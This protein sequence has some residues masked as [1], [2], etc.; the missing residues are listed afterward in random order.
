MN[1]RFKGI[2][3]IIF[4]AIAIFFLAFLYIFN[5]THPVKFSYENG[6]SNVKYE[7]ARV[8]EVTNNNLRKSINLTNIYFGSQKVKVK[9]LTGEH[10]GDIKVVQNY[11]TDIHN[12]F[13]RKGMVIVIE[14]DTVNQ[15]KYTAIVYNY[16]RA[17]VEYAFIFIFFAAL[18][19]IGGKNGFKSIIGIVF[20]LIC[21]IFLFVPM[22]YNGY[23]PI[24]ACLLIVV[25]TTFTTLFLLDGISAKTISAA[26]GTILGVVISIIVGIIFGGL[27]HLSGLNMENAETL[28]LISTKTDMRVQGL[29]LTCVIIASLGALLD[30]SVSMASS[31]QEV[32]QSN[33]KLTVKQLFKSGMNIGKDLMGTMANTLI[34]AF[35]GS[36][37]NVLVVIYAYNISFTQ[38]INMDIIS[39][40]IIEGVAG[41]LA[42]VLTVPITAFICSK[43]I[44]FIDMKLLEKNEKSINKSAV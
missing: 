43:I 30:L 17:P 34:L 26:F 18:C 41:S 15:S 19:F 1:S 39:V 11:L 35:T 3:I 25:L 27:S 28:S 9:V 33:K 40:E 32:Y 13:T 24:L 12:V 42:V 20:T 6:K 2:R 8:L 31:M 7:R 5:I 29:L 16:Y 14:I 23:S 10:K 4:S 21:I 37:L 38:M 22:I 44:P 36:S